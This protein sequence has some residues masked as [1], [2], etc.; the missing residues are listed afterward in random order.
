[1][2]SKEP[3][4]WTNERRKLRDLVP[5]EHN[6]REIYQDEAERLLKSLDEFGQIQTIAIGPDNSIYDGH[7][8]QL[9]W[10]ASERFG[11]DYEVDVRVASRPLTEEERQKLVIYLHKGTT[12]RWDWDMLGNVFDVA[13]LL[14]WG[15]DEEELQLNW[16][17]GSGT[18]PEVPF[19]EFD[20]LPPEDPFVGFRFGD[21][22][23]QVSHPVY[24][25]F[26]QAYEAQ[27]EES[28][29][30]MLDNVLRRWL[31]V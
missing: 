5:W 6:P 16:T 31:G 26:V 12:A 3:I 13:D 30:I 7:Q 22:S 8:R 29:E 9:V 20:T 11:P 28:G 10:A 25:S 23:G 1:M 24:D 14:E 19:A 2:E 27:R 15:F 21:Y 17:A 18:D 4:V